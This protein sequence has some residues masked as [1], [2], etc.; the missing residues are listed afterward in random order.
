MYALIVPSLETDMDRQSWRHWNLP[1]NKANQVTGER[2]VSFYDAIQVIPISFYVVLVSSW[3]LSPS[4]PW[5]L[6]NPK[7]GHSS[8]AAS[9]RGRKYKEFRCGSVA[10]VDV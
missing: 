7:S 2:S 10:R 6:N 3:S 8:V 5:S 1:R 9:I 4:M